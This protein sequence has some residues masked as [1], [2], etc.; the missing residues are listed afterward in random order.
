MVKINIVCD[1]IIIIMLLLYNN[2]RV[3]LNSVC[4]CVYVHACVCVCL[5]ACVCLSVRVCV[6]LCVHACV[7][8]LEI[9]VRYSLVQVQYLS[10]L[11]PSLTEEDILSWPPNKPLAVFLLSEKHSCIPNNSHDKSMQ[12]QLILQ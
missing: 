4:L 9:C 2:I 12:K 6:C 10:Y 5:C 8:V 7:V 3:S 1:I 11:L